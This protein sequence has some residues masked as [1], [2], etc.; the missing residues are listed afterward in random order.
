MLELKLRSLFRFSAWSPR[1]LKIVLSLASWWPGSRA[2][3]SR[4][5]R[6]TSARRWSQ[7]EPGG[8]LFRPVLVILNSAVFPQE[9]R[10][11]PPVLGSGNER[12]GQSQLTVI[13][14]GETFILERQIDHKGS[15]S[16]WTENVPSNLTWWRFSSPTSPISSGNAKPTHK[17]FLS[18]RPHALLS[19][20]NLLVPTPYPQQNC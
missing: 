13:R 5:S 12:E 7:A 9:L 1:Q 10:E 6:Q 11:V 20:M 16:G 19:S 8:G 14:S 4:N 17:D 3:F 2:M 18:K 15:Q